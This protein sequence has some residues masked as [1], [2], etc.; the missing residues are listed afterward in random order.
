MHF[1][2]LSEVFYL[3]HEVD[4]LL[5]IV[6]FGWFSCASSC[7]MFRRLFCWYYGLVIQGSYYHQPAAISGT[8]M[9]IVGFLVSWC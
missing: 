8:S 6:G 4:F 5:Q 3:V 7:S 2:Q 1:D 9:W